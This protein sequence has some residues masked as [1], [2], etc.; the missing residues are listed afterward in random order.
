VSH[1]CQTTLTHPQDDDS[2][3]ELVSADEDDYAPPS[4]T[5]DYESDE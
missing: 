1:A 2:V 4:V 5:S 3:P